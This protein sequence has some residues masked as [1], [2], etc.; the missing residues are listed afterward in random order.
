MADEQTALL[1]HLRSIR[2]ALVA[3]AVSVLAAGLIIREDPLAFPFL[4][5]S[6]GVCLYAFV[7]PFIHR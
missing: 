2:S 7:A 4:I 6:I 3:V 1:A 5:G